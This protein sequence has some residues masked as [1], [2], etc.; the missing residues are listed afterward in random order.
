[1]V[2]DNRQGDPAPHT[3]TGQVTLS[4]GPHAFALS[5]AWQS[6][7][8]YL[9]AY[10]TLPDGT[11]TLLGPGAFQTDGRAA[12]LE[13]APPPDTGQ[14]PAGNGPLAVTPTAILDA[15]TLLQAPRGI[16]V[17]AA[18]NLYIA[19]TDHQRIVVLD[20]AGHLVRTWG[21]AG[22][23]PGQF[24]TPE[25]VAVGPDGLIYVLDSSL[26]RIQ[27]FTS[28]GEFR[29]AIDGGWCTPAGFTVGPDGM[30]Y[31]ASTCTGASASM[32]RTARCRWSIR[33]ASTRPLT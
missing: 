7:P 23:D 2:V 26:A 1:M 21:S 15:H 4:A 9:E 11:R 25:D 31:V 28:Q 30:I 8:G 6:G 16:A 17:D 24:M 33:R 12:P 29:R 18:G 14:V 3:A 32:H 10:W 13:P 20:P 19:D 22:K 5:Y 27:V